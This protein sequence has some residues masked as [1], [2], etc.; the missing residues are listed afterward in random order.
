[1][2]CP[3]TI[4]SQS[5]ACVV[6]FSLPAIHLRTILSLFACVPSGPACLQPYA[7]DAVGSYWLYDMAQQCYMG[8]HKVW[9]LA[10]GFPLLLLVLI[11]LPGGIVLLL[12]RHRPLLNH[13]T[14]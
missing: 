5:I 3:C 9:S 14:S 11:L 10:L 7:A 12:W 8:Y 6:V 1:L 4:A 2:R 13:P